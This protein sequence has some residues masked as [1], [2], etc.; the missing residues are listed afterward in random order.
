MAALLKVHGSS[1]VLI[2][3]STDVE[4]FSTG[5]RAEPILARG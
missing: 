5:G 2:V 1:G 4:V 3:I